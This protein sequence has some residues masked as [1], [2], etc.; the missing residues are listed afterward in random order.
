M[1]H[2]CLLIRCPCIRETRWGRASPP[3]GSH[4]CTTFLPSHILTYLRSSV[5]VPP[6]SIPHASRVGDAVIVWQH[7]LPP[8]WGPVLGPLQLHSGPLS[9]LCLPLTQSCWAPNSSATCNTG[10]TFM[11]TR[12]RAQRFEQISPGFGFIFKAHQAT[13]RC[14]SGWVVSGPDVQGRDTVAW[15]QE[16]VG[17][18]GNT[19]FWRCAWQNPLMWGVRTKAVTRLPDLSDQEWQCHFPRREGSE[20][21]CSRLI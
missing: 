21:L 2:V 13:G 7:L 17:M 10:S 18:G 1:T 8:R 16:V 12:G 9:S 14:D 6:P 11:K 5:S 20:Y 4:P 15:V 3:S 19:A